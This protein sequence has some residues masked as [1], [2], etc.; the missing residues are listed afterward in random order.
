MEY[1]KYSDMGYETMALVPTMDD[2][3]DAAEEFLKSGFYSDC[4]ITKY[5]RTPGKEE[6]YAVLLLPK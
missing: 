6:A 5:K 4:K 3:I 1:S 2:A